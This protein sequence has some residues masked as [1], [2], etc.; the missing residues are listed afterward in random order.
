[1]TL[2]PLLRT[3]LRTAPRRYAVPGL[4]AD[5]GS[6]SR[7]ETALAAAIERGRLAPAD[8][9]AAPAFIAAL[10]RVTHDAWQ[11]DAAF[12]AAVLRH[13]SPSVR[14]YA[15]ISAQY[16][17]QDRRSLQ[18]AVHGF[19]HPAK[20]AR[21]P[22]G[23]ARAALA[24]LAALL[25]RADWPGLERAVARL[26]AAP[27]S[28]DL[29]PA[30]ERLQALPALARLRRLVELEAEPEVVRYRAV[31]ALLGP[32][33][34]SD[35]AFAQGAAARA[36]GDSA[37]AEA[38]DAL[39][40]LA[41]RLDRAD[42]P[43]RYR[44]VTSLRVPA[45]LA[46]DADRAKSEWDVVL[47]CQAGAAAQAW[48]LCLLV[49]VKASADAA[50]TDL[51][52]LARGLAVLAAADPAMDYAFA[53]TQGTVP[54]RGASL[55]SLSGALDETVLYCCGDAAAE[56]DGRSGVRVLSA[57]ARMQLL[58]APATLDY[59][60]R[61]AAGEPPDTALLAPLWTQLLHA[62]RWQPVRDQYAVLQRARGLMVHTA[63]L[64]RAIAETA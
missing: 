58:S 43:R 41:A 62:P 64:R 17:A 32:R 26:L 14:E 34:G 27:P 18:S 30:L 38:A 19:A 46:S 16:A 24:Q 55:A 3:V 2:P 28:A 54:I 11:R 48:D 31:L 8:A 57:A 33:Q 15:S 1:M 6:G 35:D 59:A 49:E 20:L 53:T 13:A 63:D 52:R 5:T 21:L 22:Q 42:A 37:E 61:L 9:E 10:A 23:A 29:L 25:D 60:A 40:A 51:P 47:L 7:P 36:R 4:P 56:Q 44:V 12:Q 39:R 45:T 50:A